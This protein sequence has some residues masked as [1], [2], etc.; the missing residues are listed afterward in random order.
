MFRRCFRCSWISSFCWGSMLGSNMT[1][2]K[3]KNELMWMYW[4]G[5]TGFVWGI[6][7]FLWSQRSRS[8]WFFVTSWGVPPR[9]RKY[10]MKGVIHDKGRTPLEWGQPNS[11]ELNP[12]VFRNFSFVWRFIANLCSEGLQILCR[13]SWHVDVALQSGFVG[14]FEKTSKF[15]GL[16]HH[17][18]LE[19]AILWR[20]IPNFSPTHL[21]SI[22]TKTEPL[23][24]EE[25]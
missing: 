25:V 19:M 5:C 20:I 8:N 16:E 1:T 22:R 15:E 13:S 6:A 23:G 4:I 10:C 18:P 17:F 11:V 21:L 2:E 14:F 12:N 3:N 7:G 9:L 24:C